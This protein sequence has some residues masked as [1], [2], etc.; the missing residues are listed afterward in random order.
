ML[1]C[2]VMFNFMMELRYYPATYIWDQMYYNQQKFG[3]LYT[4]STNGANDRIK[5]ACSITER[6]A[7]S[8]LAN[9]PLYDKERKE[10]EQ[11]L[12]LL[13]DPRGPFMLP[14]RRVKWAPDDTESWTEDYR[15][16]IMDGPFGFDPLDL[17]F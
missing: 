8:V 5:N 12:V 3:V 4:V 7:F 10:V 9:I 1:G 6:H 15:K 13:R 2:P 14:Y 16:Q 11:K 17:D